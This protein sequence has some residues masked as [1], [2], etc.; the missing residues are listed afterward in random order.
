M[1]SGET[2]KE[3]IPFPCRITTYGWVIIILEC[4]GSTK[5]L[6]ARRISIPQPAPV[7]QTGGSE[8]MVGDYAGSAAG[9]RYASV[10]MEE[11][12]SVHIICV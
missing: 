12:G 3:V 10:Q 7:G 8:L 6:A 11:N 1:V 2:N 9:I 5:P 4:G